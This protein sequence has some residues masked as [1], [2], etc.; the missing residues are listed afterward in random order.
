[1]AA[2]LASAGFVQRIRTLVLWEGTTNYLDDRAVDGTFV[3]LAHAIGSGSPVLFTY[4]DAG[5][6]DGTVAFAGGPTTMRAVEKAGE[7]MTFGFEP[8]AVP[9]YLAERGFDLE[10]DL[11][12]S[13]LGRRHY[14]AVPPSLPGYY[15]VVKARRR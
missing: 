5:V 4:V 7:P 3:F 1:M 9:G 14:W 11:A 15:H 10:S 2:E 13:E 12:V 6:L 8:D